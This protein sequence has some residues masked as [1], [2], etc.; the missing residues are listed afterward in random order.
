MKYTPF[1]TDEVKAGATMT[2]EG[3]I[4]PKSFSGVE[5]EHEAIRSRAGITDF[6]AMGE[7]DIKGKGSRKFLDELCVNQVSKLLPGKVLYTTFLN[8]DAEIID[9]TTIYCFG[10]EHFG[11]VTSALNRIRIFDWLT[12]QAKDKEIYV[13]DLSSAIGL[14]SVQGPMSGKMLAPLVEDNIQNLEYFS[15]IKTAVA[16][17]TPAIVSRTGF[18]GEL[19]F[20]VYVYSENGRDLWKAL[21]EAGREYDALF[22]GIDAAV[23]TIP[24][25]KG[26][27][28]VREYGDHIN[29]LEV[30]L[31]WS[32]KW[33]KPYFIGQKRLLEIKEKG[34]VK[35]LKGF[36]VKNAEAKIDL[37]SEIY[38]EG[39]MVGKV[40]S[41]QYGYTVKK[42]IGLCFIETAFANA[43][44]EI[45]IKN[46]EKF[47]EATIADKTFYDPKN[48]RCK[49]K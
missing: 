19:G 26:Y 44:Q 12:D 37:G 43:G 31:D 34:L 5:K 30:G 42:S 24:L 33:K 4:I 14:L 21:Q 48:E 1:Y 28:T 29:P 39:K 16:G 49:V 15:F 35:K 40:T 13:T 46:K 32:V 27:L 18:T 6:S 41:A 23:Q 10:E 2:T 22:C 20:E 7:I 3:W 36:V 9:D 45:N 17:I 11:V 47:I 38:I 25:E 8:E